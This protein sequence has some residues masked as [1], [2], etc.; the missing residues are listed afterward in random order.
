MFLKKVVTGLLSYVRQKVGVSR[1]LGDEHYKGLARVRVGTLKNPYCLVAMSAEYK[2][3]SL[4]PAMVT[5]P[6]ELNI[7]QWDEH[8]KQKTM[9]KSISKYVTTR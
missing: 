3:C 6:Y 9:P 7:L 2:I 8:T 5:S 4:L 1:V